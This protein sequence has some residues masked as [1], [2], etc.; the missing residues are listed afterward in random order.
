MKNRQ[1][2]H[3]DLE[4]IRRYFPGAEPVAMRT[5]FDLTPRRRRVMA[6]MFRPERPLKH[7]GGK[8]RWTM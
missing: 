3:E 4:Q 5:P 6:D 1:Y 2:L 7:W 8:L